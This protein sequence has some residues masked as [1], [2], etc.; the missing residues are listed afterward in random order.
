[1]RRLAVLAAAVFVPAVHAAGPDLPTPTGAQTAP[2]LPQA[3]GN[4]SGERRAYNAR[5]EPVPSNAEHSCRRQEPAGREAVPPC[6][7]KTLNCPAA[8]TYTFPFATVTYENLTAPPGLSLA[9]F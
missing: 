7:P 6:R 3:G 1:M 5:T 8:A 9:L 2:V 4:G